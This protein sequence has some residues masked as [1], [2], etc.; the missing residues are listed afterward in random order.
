MSRVP[1]AERLSADEFL[2]LPHDEGVRWRQLIEGELIVNEPSWMHN[3]SQ[4]TILAALRLWVRAGDARGGVN[5]PVD[6]L[7]DDRNVYKPDV[8]WY[9]EGRSPMRGDP[10]PYAPPDLAVE[11]R[12]RSTWR[13]DVGAKKANYERYGVAELWLV[14]TAADVVLVFRC[15]SAASPAFDV[16]EEL[17]V[18]ATLTSPLLAGFALRVAEIFGD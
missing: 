18:G 2:A 16:S 12:S 17:D 7:L 15:S 1:T 4:L 6:V 8:V 9:R 5:L 13:Y 3:D 11:V 14:D 10:P